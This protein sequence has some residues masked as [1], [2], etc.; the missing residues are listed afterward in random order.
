[1]ASVTRDVSAA[2][3]AAA[4]TATVAASCCCCRRAA[5]S[6]S[7]SAILGGLGVP[8]STIPASSTARRLPPGVS[9]SPLALAS[10]MRLLGTGRSAS[11][12]DISDARSR[13]GAWMDV[14]DVRLG[15]ATAVGSMLRR[16]EA[17]RTEEEGEPGTTGPACVV[18]GL[19]RPE[20]VYLSPSK[21]NL[22]VAPLSACLGSPLPP[23][24]TP[25]VSSMSGCSRRASGSVSSVSC[26]SVSA[27]E[28]PESAARRTAEAAQRRRA[29]QRRMA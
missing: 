29:P 21:G 27:A 3:A 18:L 15:R 17:R 26:S 4:L 5:W 9:I 6:P 11:I 23:S 22:T 2:A 7:S 1:M 13:G 24:S 10:S 8:L 25:M 28:T 20:G 19:D 16:G 12:L 14:E